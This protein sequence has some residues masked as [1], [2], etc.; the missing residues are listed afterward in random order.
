MNKRNIRIVS[1]CVLLLL[2]VFNTVAQPQDN[3]EERVAKLEEEVEDL[4]RILSSLNLTDETYSSEKSTNNDFADNTLNI[5]PISVDLLSLTYNESNASNDYANDYSD[6]I[7]F[8]FMFKN[9]FEKPIRAA[10]GT[11]VFMDVF[12]EQWWSIGL[13]LNDPIEPGKQIS[14]IGQIDYNGFIDSHKIARRTDP[15]DVKVRYDVTQVIFE[16][17]TQVTFE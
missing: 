1:T 17:G 15:A 4:K 5:S 11:I 16:D 6:W 3:L 9:N 14:W 13:T 10:K 2:I 7:S 12:G 8:T